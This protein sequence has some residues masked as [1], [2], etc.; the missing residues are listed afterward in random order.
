MLKELT[1]TPLPEKIVL[2]RC[3]DPD[4]DV[5]LHAIKKRLK[6]A[7]CK[8]VREMPLTGGAISLGRHFEFADEQLRT[9]I[10]RGF[11][12]IMLAVHTACHHVEVNKLL[13][14]GCPEHYFL[15]E[16]LAI[17]GE[18]ILKK[19]PEMTVFSCVINT[20]EAD[21]GVKSVEH[22]RSSHVHE[23]EFGFHSSPRLVLP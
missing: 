12:G 18:N 23:F 14:E 1:A 20:H 16:I 11:F 13:P 15:E 2:V 22:F 6:R 17:G 3:F 21:S 8:Q 10:D 7:G 4:I 9:F 19:F 5:A